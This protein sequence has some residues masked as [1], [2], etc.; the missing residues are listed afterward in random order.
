[1][2]YILI[3][4]LYSLVFKFGSWIG[5]L[6]LC[7]GPWNRVNFVFSSFHESYS[8]TSLILTLLA[9]SCCKIF[10]NSIFAYPKKMFIS[11]WEQIKLVSST[12]IV[13]TKY[14]EARQ[15]SFT[16]IRK[17]S[18]SRKIFCMI[19]WFLCSIYCFFQ[20][21]LPYLNQ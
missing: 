11:L 4:I 7:F 18:G 21:Y 17:S 5:K 9:V 3:L 2:L 20:R 13:G 12:D 14:L 19:K 6:F 1:M 10:S 16:Y 15:I 8:N